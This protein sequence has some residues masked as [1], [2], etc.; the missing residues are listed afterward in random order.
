MWVPIHLPSS[1]VYLVAMLCFPPLCSVVA[2]VGR[3]TRGTICPEVVLYVP[4]LP[5]GGIKCLVEI[6]NPLGL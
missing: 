2:L 5:T 6:Q 3:G 1:L 4:A